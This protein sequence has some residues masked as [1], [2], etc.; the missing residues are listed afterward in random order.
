[1]PLRRTRPPFRFALLHLFDHPRG[2]LFP[3]S[4]AVAACRSRCVSAEAAGSDPGGGGFSASGSGSGLGAGEDATAS[5]SRL[6][7]AASWAGVA[8]SRCFGR[9]GCSSAI[10]LRGPGLTGSSTTA[11][12]DCPHPA[13]TAARPNAVSNAHRP[14][15][16]SAPCTDH[17]VMVR[18][19]PLNP[20]RRGWDSNPRAPCDA[21]S[22]RDCP[23]QPL[24]H[25]SGAIGAPILARAGAIRPWT[26]LTER[27]EHPPLTQGPA[28]GRR[29][30]RRPNGFDRC[31]T[32]VSPRDEA[33]F[34]ID[35]P[36]RNW[37]CPLPP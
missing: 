17:S 3:V 29:A 27:K 14:A 32:G 31:N 8:T 25:P 5:T 23:V 24:R 9:G 13:S 30:S 37:P 2:D 36:R 26:T 11:V 15:L 18:R 20:Q 35:S 21:N 4:R 6:T 16:R 7:A 28:G 1:M 34:Q 22:F 33:S 12:E 10:R 19:R